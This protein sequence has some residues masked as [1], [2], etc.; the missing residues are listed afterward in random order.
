MS[1][2]GIYM[3]I[4]IGIQES[5]EHP[6]HCSAIH[7]RALERAPVIRDRFVGKG[8]A[9]LSHNA[10]YSAKKRK[11]EHEEKRKYQWFLLVCKIKQMNQLK[12]LGF[13]E[14]QRGNTVDHIV[15]RIVL[16]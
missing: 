7:S 11:V 2:L 6:A 4:K 5:S 15:D 9:L 8:E 13:R 16:S 12:L 1:L 3:H 10:N 14:D